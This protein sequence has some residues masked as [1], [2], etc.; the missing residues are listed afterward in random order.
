MGLSVIIGV[1]SGG[2][3]TNLH[4]PLMWGRGGWGCYNAAPAH[5]GGGGVAA[6]YNTT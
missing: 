4:A 5:G 6:G 2:R 3:V 1:G